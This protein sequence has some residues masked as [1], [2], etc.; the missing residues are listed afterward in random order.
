MRAV[1]AGRTLIIGYSS[2]SLALAAGHLG[3]VYNIAQFTDAA[4]TGLI[5]NNM[6]YPFMSRTNIN[7]KSAAQAL[8]SSI[9]HYA[10]IQDGWSNIAVIG[11]PDRFSLDAAV[12]FIETAQPELNVLTFQLFLVGATEFGIELREIKCSGARVIVAFLS[13]EWSNFLEHADAFGLVGDNYVYYV[14]STVVAIPLI[15]NTRSRGAIGYNVFVP[16]DS[17]QLSLFEQL[18]STVD[19][20]EF[21]QAGGPFNPFQLLAYDTILGVAHAMAKLES[22]GKLDDGHIDGATWFDAINSLE[23]EGT[24][25]HITFNEVGDRIADI[26]FLY[27]SPEDGWIRTAQYSDEGYSVINDVV[28]HS[29]SEDVPDLDIREPFRYWSC[30][31]ED[32]GVDETG[33]TVTLHTP[34]G[35]DIDDI[36][37]DYHCDTFIDCQNFSDES[38]N[39]SNNYYV[40]FIVFG[41]ITGILVFIALGNITFVFLFGIVLQYRRVRRASPPF[42]ILLLLSI[43]VGY[44][45]VFAWFGKPHPVACGFQPWLLGLSSISMIVALSVK[46]FRV[47]R[48]FR[49]RMERVLITNIELFV[50]WFLFM[51][52]ALVILVLW[53]IIS[54]PTADMEHLAGEDHYVCTTGGFTGKPGGLIFFFLFVAYGAFILLFG[55]FISFVSRHV[56]NEY[57]ESKLLTISIYNLGFLSMVIIPVYMV[58]NNE[59]PFSAWILRTCAIL[60]GFTATMI[61][62]FAPILWGIFVTDKGKNI[63]E[64]KSKLSSSTFRNSTTGA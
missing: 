24:T 20:E 13:F 61:L 26:E 35:S 54:T 1:E 7:S 50:Y 40:V 21:P 18:W 41:I 57:N 58:L 53:S 15:N 51:V 48:I 17:P 37:I 14:P 33:K 3:I 39:C 10:Q 49:F 45:S 22:E 43:I 11:K 42:L 8:K 38:K 52:P 47:W 4:S 28:W 62:Q 55:A 34:D 6:A 9:L 44:C 36:D 60:Y 27:Y 5:A 16:E 64:F 63:R 12:S 30:H 19:P 2:S 29:G 46:I 59:N 31:S 56:P 32:D 25:G 23:Y